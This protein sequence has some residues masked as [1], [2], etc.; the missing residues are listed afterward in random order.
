MFISEKYKEGI[1]HQK[2][3]D[4]LVRLRCKVTA[5]D[6]NI[7]KSLK[8]LIPLVDSQEMLFSIHTVFKNVLDVAPP[9]ENPNDNENVRTEDTII[10]VP[11]QSY[12]IENMIFALEDIYGADYN[13]KHCTYR[14]VWKDEAGKDYLVPL[15]GVESFEA[16]NPNGAYSYDNELKQLIFEET[17]PY[18]TEYILRRY[19]Y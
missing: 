3:G 12:V 13:G 10:S 16:A 7:Y 6:E 1:I 18:A 14:I 2:N 9:T 19:Y 8:S 5:S 4:I 17:R 11:P 15:Y